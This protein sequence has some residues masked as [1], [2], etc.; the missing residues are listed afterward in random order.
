MR[1]LPSRAPRQRHP[2]ILVAP[3]VY[4]KPVPESSRRVIAFR[5]DTGDVEEGSVSAVRA[6]KGRIK[7]VEF[8]GRVKVPEEEQLSIVQHWLRTAIKEYGQSISDERIFEAVRSAMMEN[9]TPPA[10]ERIVEFE[11]FKGYVVNRLKGRPFVQ[12]RH[13]SFPTRLI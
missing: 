9:Q 10:D 5:I 13:S 7:G 12:K 3:I 4:Q 2:C 11:I 8:L 1:C 6:G